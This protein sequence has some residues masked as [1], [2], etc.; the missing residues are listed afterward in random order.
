MLHVLLCS[1]GSAHSSTG[2]Q[3]TQTCAKNDLH[4]AGSEVTM[5]A[6]ESTDILKQLE[7]NFDLALNDLEFAS[8]QLDSRMKDATRYNCCHHA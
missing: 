6:L 3:S 2:T 4:I 7:I 5:V 8:H 1:A